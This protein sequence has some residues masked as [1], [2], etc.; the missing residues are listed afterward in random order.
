M[1]DRTPGFA[2]NGAFVLALRI[3]WPGREIL[4]GKWEPSAIKKV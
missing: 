4:D 1:T 2:P 3:Y